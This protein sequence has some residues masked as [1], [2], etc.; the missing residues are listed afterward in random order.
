[1]R[2]LGYLILFVVVGLSSCQQ[3]PRTQL[4]FQAFVTIPAGLNVGFSHNFNIFD[5]MGINNDEIID[6]QPA[7]VR[8]TVEYGESNADFIEQAF[9]YTVDGSTVQEIGFQTQLPINNTQFAE[10]FP[11]ILDA[12]NHITQETF[13]MRLKLIF[14]SIPIT[15]T[16]IRIDFGFQATVGG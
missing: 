14:R 10:L 4:P 8:L 7:Y 1:M 16:R 13:D 11:S 12:R 5:I 2:H 6:A 3:A 9:F 15:E